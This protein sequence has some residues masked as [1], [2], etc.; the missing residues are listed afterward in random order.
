M[1]RLTRQESREQTRQSLI[2]AAEQ[3]LLRVGIYEASIRR[4]CV[5]AGY[6]LGAFY[7]NFGNK[8]ELLMEVVEIHTARLFSSLDELIDSSNTPD[9]KTIAKEIGCWLKEIQ[10]DQILSNLTLEF[11]LYARHNERFS[12]IYAANKERWRG[13]L[14]QSLGKLFDHLGQTPTMPLKQLALALS[15]LWQGLVLESVVPGTDAADTII[16]VLLNSL[17]EKSQA[18]SSREP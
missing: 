9:F 17:L 3:E 11:T 8:D 2:H 18:D 7:S 10:M 15:A 12:I 14:A 13:R 16:P 6:T 1:K 4:I 5:T